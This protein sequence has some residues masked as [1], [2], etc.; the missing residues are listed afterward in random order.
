VITNYKLALNPL[1]YQDWSIMNRACLPINKLTV[2]DLNLS[3]AN[4]AVLA[5]L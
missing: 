1:W 3:W 5:V 4:A 2:K